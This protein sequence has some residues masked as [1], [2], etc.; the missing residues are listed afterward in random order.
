MNESNCNIHVAVECPHSLWDN[1]FKQ[2]NE[3]TQDMWAYWLGEFIQCN[4]CWAI[5][6]KQEIFWWLSKD[7]YN[8][9]VASIMR[10]LN[11]KDIPCPCCRWETRFIYWKENINAIR[12]RLTQSEAFIV[13]CRDN[14]GSIV[15]YMDMYIDTL[16][17]IYKRELASH[18]SL[19][20]IEEIRR[21][22]E[23]IL[24]GPTSEMIS[25]SAMWMLKQYMNMYLVYKIW[26]TLSSSKIPHAYEAMPGI[27]EL[28]R[29]N[30][31]SS[32]YTMMWSRSLGFTEEDAYQKKIINIGK[33]Y[34][35]DI[36]TFNKPVEDFR[37]K[38]NV[39]LKQFL[40]AYSKTR[41]IWDTWKNLLYV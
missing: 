32:M 34:A 22:T 14:V 8:N 12:E 30:N 19:I 36:V 35:S 16:D 28:D 7:I 15:G 6:W 41:K 17:V 38:F 4:T 40:R 27:T 23:K 3:V 25:F 39:W 33:N 26:S 2:L 21:R 10:T 24:W 11:I 37:T 20:G 9:T 13:I 5:Q 29:N 1:D 31:L 18:Y